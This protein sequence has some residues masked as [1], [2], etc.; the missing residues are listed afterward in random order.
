MVSAAAR[1]PL[2]LYCEL[3]VPFQ[4]PYCLVS[5]SELAAYEKYLQAL[6]GSLLPS[7]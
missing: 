5:L 6:S 3:S 4:Q 1:G 7:A 2:A